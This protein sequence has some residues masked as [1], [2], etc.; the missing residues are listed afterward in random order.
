[1]QHQVSLVSHLIIFLPPSQDHIAPDCTQHLW[2][3]RG[4]SA[5]LFTRSVNELHH[6]RLGFS[7]LQ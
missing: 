5:Q 7:S 1:M 6:F 2:K 4:A 3:E